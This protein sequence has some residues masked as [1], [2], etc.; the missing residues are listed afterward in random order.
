MKCYLSMWKQTG[1]L[2]HWDQLWHCFDWLLR[3]ALNVANIQ[4]NIWPKLWVNNVR[5][6]K[7]IKCL[8]WLVRATG[9]QRKT[10]HWQRQPAGALGP[11]PSPLLQH[12]EHRRLHGE[13]FHSTS[14]QSTLLQQCYKSTSLTQSEVDI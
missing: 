12:W 14:F 10:S 7:T 1:Y 6:M 13:S 3:V 11:I 2:F 4:S 5:N 9:V 8:R